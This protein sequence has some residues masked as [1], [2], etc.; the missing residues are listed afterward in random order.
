VSL[1]GKGILVTRAA[2]QAQELCVEIERRGGRAFAL[3]TIRIL[4]PE[5]WEECDLAIRMLT[6]FDAIAFT[7]V[8]AVESFFG[9]CAAL[10]V[11]IPTIARCAVCAVGVKTAKALGKYGVRSRLV[12]ERFSG[13]GLLESLV[14]E[15]TLEKSFLLPRG[16]RA[17]DDIAQELR[18]RGARVTTVTV[19]RT[20]GPEKDTIDEIRRVFN[21][22]LVNVVTF[23]SPSAV[24]G[25]IEVL[26]GRTR[27]QLGSKIWTAVIGDTTRAAL[28][29][30]RIPVSITAPQATGSALLE[31]IEQFDIQDVSQ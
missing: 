22:R 3:P 28:E 15:D 7:S 26:D 16:D 20:A 24:A 23:F 10:S 11:D 30:Y 8:N 19:Y 12:P 5:Y 2:D 4:P 18:R 14:P 29:Q 25:L 9:R 1:A 27:S 21:E 6:S 13:K 31:A 17:R